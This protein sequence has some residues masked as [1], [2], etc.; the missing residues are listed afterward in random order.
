MHGYPDTRIDSMK[1]LERYYYEEVSQEALMVKC[2]YGSVVLDMYEL[3]ANLADAQNVV[4][5]KLLMNFSRSNDAS[6]DASDESSLPVMKYNLYL[7][8]FKST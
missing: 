3:Y 2:L 5:P 1:Q 8:V 4:K 6:I 7:V